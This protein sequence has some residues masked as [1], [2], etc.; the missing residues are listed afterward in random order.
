VL[1]ATRLATRDAHATSR[2]LS[3]TIA[4]GRAQEIGLAGA[5]QRAHG[6]PQGALAA[7][8]GLGCRLGHGTVHHVHAVWRDG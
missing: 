1:T 7:G 5:V 2:I 3:A 4:A 6:C 8:D